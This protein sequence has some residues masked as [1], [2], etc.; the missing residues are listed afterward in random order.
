MRV[1]FQGG[2]LHLPI[3][4]TMTTDEHEHVNGAVRMDIWAWSEVHWVHVG[5]G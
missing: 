3:T 4:I 1:N 5:T 2:T